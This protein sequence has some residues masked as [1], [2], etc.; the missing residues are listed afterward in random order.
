[1]VGIRIRIGNENIALMNFRQ[2]ELNRFEINIPLFKSICSQL[3]IAV[4]NII[5]NEKITRK[6]QEKSLLLEFSNNIAAIRD[7]FLLAKVLTNQLNKLFGIQDYAI[8]ALSEDKKTHRPILYDPDAEITK[9]PVFQQMIAHP[10]DVNDGVF[11]SVLNATDPLTFNINDWVRSSKP[12]TYTEAAVSLGIVKLTGIAIRVGGEAIAVMNFRHDDSNRFEINKQLFK[13]ICSQLATAVSNIIANEKIENQLIEINKYKQQL[14]EEKIYLKE[15]IATTLNYAEIIGESPEIQKIFRLVEQVA[16]SDSTVLLLGE[17]G[18]GKELVARAIHNASSRKNKLMVKINCAALPANLIESELF[19]H[20]RGSFTGAIERRIGKFELANNGT[21]FLDEIGEMPLE[22]QVK[23][24]R[25]LQEQEIERV[26]GKTTIKVDVRII[27]ATNRD[28]ENE[29]AAGRFRSDLYYRLNIFPINLPALRN[30]K[31]DIPI[32]ASSFITRFAKKSGKQI[33]NLSKKALQDLSQYDWPGNIRELEHM[34]ERSVLLTTGDTIKEIYLPS[35]KQNKSTP[36]T[37][38]VAVAKT[39]DD[40]E[41]EHILK[42]LKHVKG[43]IAGEGG[44]AELLGVPPS[45][46]NSKMKRLGISR[47]FTV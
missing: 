36:V 34:I 13:S 26:G 22:L 29:M 25:V 35:A 31:E 43:R 40:N 30:R 32:L 42:I 24:L 8:H 20:E 16:D 12:P 27:A 37:E 47:K 19:G 33:N 10:S 2:D 15:E 28:L 14:E 46:L 41:K 4:S 6:E 7:K 45:T 44:A 1:M 21:L 23:L 18:T 39:I 9:A 11:N 3:A 5:A 38:E 17:T